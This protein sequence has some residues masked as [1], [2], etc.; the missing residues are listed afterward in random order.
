MISK[1][2]KLVPEYK[3]RNDW[4]GKVINWEMCK[5]F[6]LD[7]TNPSSILEND[8]NKL[9]WDFDIQTDHLISARRPDIIIIIKKKREFFKIVDLAVPADHI[10]KLKKRKKKDKYLDFAR[11]LKK[12]WN[13][14]VTIIPI[15][16]G[17]FGT[18][19]KGLLKGL[20]DLEV[21]GRVETIKTTALLR[22]ARILR[23][24]LET[25]GDLLSFKLQWKTIS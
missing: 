12:L 4:V 18:V 16:I 9:L 3:I 8:T 13:M 21:G 11:E 19:T 25:W 22:T 7:N 17:A 5:K 6:K 10:I 20:E 14:K 15:V 23:R 2:S 24:V 1:C